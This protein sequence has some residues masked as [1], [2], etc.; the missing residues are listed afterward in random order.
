MQQQLEP[1]Q[2]QDAQLGPL[3][4]VSAY[5]SNTPPHSTLGLSTTCSL[6]TIT[7]HVHHHNHGQAADAP[8]HGSQCSSSG[9]LLPG[10]PQDLLSSSAAAALRGEAVRAA[11]GAGSDNGV[12][13]AK[14][15]TVDLLSLS[16]R[17]SITLGSAHR[18]PSMTRAIM[19][20]L[21]GQ[22]ARS[23]LQH[24]AA[25]GAFP[26]ALPSPRR[27]EQQPST[28]PPL[29][30]GPGSSHA[31]LSCPMCVESSSTSNG[32]AALDVAPPCQLTQPNARP[33]TSPPRPARQE[34]YR[35]P[36]PAAT[37]PAAAAAAAGGEAG[38]RSH[39]SVSDTRPAVPAESVAAQQPDRRSADFEP[40]P[41]G[42]GV[43]AAAGPSRAPSAAHAAVVGAFDAQGVPVAGSQPRGG[44]LT[45]H[46][47]A[48]G[49]RP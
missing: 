10:V 6:T 4:F 38:S 26:T 41:A 16:R 2:Q 29:T 7:H 20:H 23:A 25:A 46:R 33:P 43:V 35:T 32:S 19:G 47:H 40:P 36:V 39:L 18:Q 31:P 42:W 14:P 28:S 5:D 3:G 37:V 34:G 27:S 22:Q 12:A 17:G 49:V 48:G 15:Y 1:Q 30:D 44:P 45:P 8:M 13:P 11:E 21:L 9:A 24:P